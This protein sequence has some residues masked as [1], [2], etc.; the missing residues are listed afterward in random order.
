MFSVGLLPAAG[1][2]VAWSYGRELPDATFGALV[3]LPTSRREIAAAKA[4]ALTAW[5]VVVVLLAVG[6]RW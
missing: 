2:V 6:R 1:V 5:G 4:V 3:A